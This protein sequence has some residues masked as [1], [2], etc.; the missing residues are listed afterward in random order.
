[1]VVLD[2]VDRRIAG[3]LLAGAATVD[4]LVAVTATP[5]AAVLAALT[6]LEASGLASGTHGRYRPVGPLAVAS[7]A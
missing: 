4:E 6:R 1:M 2:P 5:V 7:A 3:A